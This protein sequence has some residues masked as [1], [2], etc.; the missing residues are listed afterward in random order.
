MEAL[1]LKNGWYVDDNNNRW[2]TNV[3]TEESARKKSESLKSCF[4]CSGCSDCSRCFGCSDCSRCFGCSG[5]K[6]FKDN[7]QRY[8]T[9]R[10]GSRN[11]QTTLYWNS[12]KHQVF[13]CLAN[14]DT[15]ET[16][17]AR[18]RKVHANTEHLQPYL[19]QIEIMKYLLKQ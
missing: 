17:E 18:V 11:A 14:R 2:N 3:E 12:E 8:T 19:K 5:I 16:F 1:K 6:D 15:I 9:P 13:V 10:I 4:G 7:P